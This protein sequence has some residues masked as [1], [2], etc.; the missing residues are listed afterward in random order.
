MEITETRVTLVDKPNSRLRAYASITFD[1]C[2]VVRDLRIIEGR[3]GYFVAMPSHK[4]EIPCPKC[5]SK[6]ALRAKY[7][8]QCGAELSPEK[9]EEAGNQVTHRDL[10]HPITTEFRNYLQKRVIEDYEK[11]KSAPSAPRERR[12]VSEAKEEVIPSKVKKESPSKESPSLEA[13]EEKA[14][15]EKTKEEPSPKASD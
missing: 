6:N 7:C 1:D 11:E 13:K 3:N 12:V 10:A 5:H 2:F 14:V 9:L 8:N 15:P 4:T